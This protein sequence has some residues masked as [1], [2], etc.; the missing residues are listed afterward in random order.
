MVLGPLSGLHAMAQITLTDE[1]IELKQQTF[2]VAEVTDERAR[3]APV[4]ELAIKGADNKIRLEATNL[5]AGPA[6]AFTKYL[7]SGLPKNKA[8]WPVIIQIK[9]MQIKETAATPGRIDGQI[10]LTLAF[11]LEKPYGFEH[12]LDYPGRL[13][14]TRSPDNAASVER[15]L[16]SMLKGGLVYL[17]DWIKDNANTSRKL[18]KN[19][20]IGFSDYSEKTEGDTI[21]YSAKRPLTW[22]DFQSKLRPTG[23]YQAAVMPSIG[24]TQEAKVEQ[25]TIEVKVAMKTYVPKSACWANY[26]GRDDYALNHEQRHFDVVK[27]VAEQFKKKVLA[28][29]LSPDTYEAFINMQYLDSFRDMDA[30]QKAYDGETAHGLNRGA[31]ENWN[32]RIDKELKTISQ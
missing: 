19:V 13:H 29:K 25:G 7:E 6:S 27:I 3:K 26:S 23:P 22:A 14:Y 20:K 8:L 1:T 30:M 4:A 24:Y 32:A 15:N 12:L 16:R 21:Y 10:S 17:N 9:Q 31:Q 2:Y 5:Q 28:K 18:A 11:G